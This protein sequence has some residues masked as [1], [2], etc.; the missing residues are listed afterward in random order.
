[1][2]KRINWKAVLYTFIWVVSLSG[3][4]VFMS[5]IEVQKTEVRCSDVKVFIP[6]NR[7]FIDRAELDSILLAQQ[8]PLV[9]RTLNKINIQQLE[10]ALKANP[11]IKMARIYADMDGVVHVQIEQRE[12]VLRILNFA[13]QDFYIDRNGL[14]IPIS[15]NFTARVLVASGMILEGFNG[16]VDTLSTTIARGLYEAASFI[17]KDTLWNDQIEQLYVNAQNEIEMVPRVGNHK[18]VLGTADSLNIKFRNLL[19]FYKDTL[20]KAGWEAYKTISLKY[21]NQIVCEKNTLTAAADSIMTSEPTEKPVDD[22]I[23]VTRTLTKIVK[24]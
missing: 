13:N 20:P 22:S 24:N 1:M 17:E 4:V 11:F 19:R 8:G 15:E 9:G 14:K 18:I 7:S 23:K 2:L 21:A 3:L 16:K 12:P 10:N 5:F 6:G